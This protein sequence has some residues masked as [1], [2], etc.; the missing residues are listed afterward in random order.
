M[1][2][3]SPTPASV[4]DPVSTSDC[5]ASRRNLV[6]KAGFCVKACSLQQKLHFST[7]SPHFGLSP[8]FSPALR[9]GG[10]A[11]FSGGA[12]RAPGIHSRPGCRAK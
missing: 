10:G 1:K 4:E 3:D 8:H 2:I 7:A 11:A 12:F 6:R 5:T 9:L